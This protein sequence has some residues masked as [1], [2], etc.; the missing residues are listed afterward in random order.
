MAKR[1]IPKRD[2]L[3]FCASYVTTVGDADDKL[4]NYATGWFD[5]SADEAREVLR[6]IATTLAP[7]LPRS[8]Q[9]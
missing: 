1:K 9:E 7:P 3:A 2:A 4:V 8:A 5:C 6:E